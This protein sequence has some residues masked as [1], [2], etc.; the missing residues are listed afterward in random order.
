MGATLETEAQKQDVRS[1]IGIPFSIWTPNLGVP[2]LK[3]HRVGW[4][5]A[6]KNRDLSRFSI[7][8]RDRW[9]RRRALRGAE[10]IDDCTHRSTDREQLCISVDVLG[11]TNGQFLVA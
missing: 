5:L 8:C 2:P 4:G 6:S 1:A 10:G 11:Y 7:A 3:L 9:S